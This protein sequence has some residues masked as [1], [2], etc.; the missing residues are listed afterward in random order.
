[1]YVREY[2]CTYNNNIN[3]YMHQ[4][5]ALSILS[6]GASPDGADGRHIIAVLDHIQS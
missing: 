4:M 5:Q 2:I 3:A 6:S 1:M